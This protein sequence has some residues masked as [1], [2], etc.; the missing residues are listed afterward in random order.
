VYWVRALELRFAGLCPVHTYWERAMELLLEGRV[1]PLPIVS[2]RF[3]LED[4]SKGYE[5]FDR[6]EASKVLLRP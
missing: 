4:A 2:H 5:L 3:A 1:D 6:R